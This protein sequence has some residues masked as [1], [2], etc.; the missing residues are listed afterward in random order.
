MNFTRLYYE[1]KIAARIRLIMLFSKLCIILQI[2]VCRPIEF[3][4]HENLC[5][6]IFRLLLAGAWYGLSFRG[7]DSYSTMQGFQLAKIADKLEVGGVAGVKHGTK[8]YQCE[9]VKVGRKFLI[10]HLPIRV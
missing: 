9:I 8:I 4:R 5:Y 6:V 7:E 3:C 10:F 2:V 1:K